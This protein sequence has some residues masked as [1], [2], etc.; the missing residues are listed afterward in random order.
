[1][2][3]FGLGFCIGFLVG[4]LVMLILYHQEQNKISKGWKRSLP[5][6]D[7]DIPMPET[8]PPKTF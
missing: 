4:F 6:V 1:M 8:K 2:I 5:E 7:I 3:I